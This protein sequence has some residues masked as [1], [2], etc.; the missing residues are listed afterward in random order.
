LTKAGIDLA[1]AK[2]GEPDAPW[3]H[4]LMMAHWTGCAKE[5]GSGVQSLASARLRTQRFELPVLYLPV[6][7]VCLPIT[8]RSSAQASVVYHFQQSPNT[9]GA[10][11]RQQAHAI[12]DSSPF[13]SKF[14]AFFAP[15]DRVESGLAGVQAR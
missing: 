3:S 8:P 14:G 10:L 2:R 11:D 12:L 13:W 5:R 4:A 7:D 1:A 9:G 6:Y 15:F